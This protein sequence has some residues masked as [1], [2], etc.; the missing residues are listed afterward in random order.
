MN[1]ISI[2]R[3]EAVVALSF[4]S[5]LFALP[6]QAQTDD[7]TLINIT[8]LEQLDAMRY[9]LDGDGLPTS[10]GQTDYDAAF[11]V[12]STVDGDATTPNASATS[13][14][15]ELRESLD[16]EVD[17]SYATSSRNLAWIDPTN[18]GT[19]DTPGWLPIGQSSSKSFNT[20]FEGNNH[21]ISNLYI[22]SFS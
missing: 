5:L 4:V 15:Y 9:D 19:T 22:R 21:T 2:P 8:N 1:L 17:A 13:T 14:G 20:M 11:G 18:G 16:F 6:L 7:P 10:A 3:A 12:T